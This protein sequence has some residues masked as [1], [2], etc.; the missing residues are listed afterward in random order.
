MTDLLSE[1]LF[2]TKKELLLEWMKKQHY[3]SSHEVIRN[4]LDNFYIRSD[5]TKRD[6]LEQGIIRKLPEKEKHFRG[7]RGKDAWY[8]YVGVS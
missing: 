7:F 1:D 4:G 6:F 3:F 8:E 5:R 2:K